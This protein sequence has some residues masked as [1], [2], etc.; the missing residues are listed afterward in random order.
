VI[1]LQRLLLIACLSALA[2]A[3]AYGVARSANA[4]PPLGHLPN[5]PA[6]PDNLSSEQWSLAQTRTFEAQATT[7][8]SPLVRVALLDTGID[9]GH[10]EFA[11]RID[12]SSSVSCATETET[13]NP[14]PPAWLDDNGHGTHLAGVIAAGDNGFGIVGVAPHVQLVVVK[15]ARR[16]EPIRPGAVACAFDWV[17]GHHIDV[18]NASFAVDKGPTPADDPLDFY[19]R[20][21]PSERAAIKLVHNA[22]QGAR[23]S[24]TTIVASAGNNNLDLADPPLGNDCIRMP[25]ELPG[26]IG[27]SSDGR[28]GDRARSTP[29]GPSNYGVGVIDVVAPGGDD[30]QGGPV[31]GRILSTFPSYIPI[32]PNVPPSIVDGPPRSTY[33]YSL[34]T[35]QAAAHVTGV[36][37]LIISRFGELASP[38]NGKM[39]PGRV[40]AF[41]QATAESKPCT[42]D[43]ECQGGNGYNG[44]FGHGEVDA[45][46]AI[47]H[48]PGNGS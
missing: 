46:S 2:L 11:G 8:G 29:P 14:A 26:V 20:D 22:I 16:G 21:N 19:C 13:P 1:P 36:A 33:R 38:Q 24:G 5:S 10:P 23:R 44:F 37:A 39:R 40:K 4:G 9:Q 32:P 47:L 48:E 12:F 7:G 43:P 34:G 42:P 27:V 30:L 17:A 15:V 45:L 31:Q 3:P 28:F 35:S 18:A 6:T 41:V 25:V